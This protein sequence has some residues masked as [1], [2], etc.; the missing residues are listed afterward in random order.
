VFA[1]KGLEAPAVVVT[2]IEAVNTEHARDVLYV[3]VTRA[4]DR[5]IILVHDDASRDLLEI[6][7]SSAQGKSADD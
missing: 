4:L 2:D 3:G 7:A 5:L 6:L 1:F